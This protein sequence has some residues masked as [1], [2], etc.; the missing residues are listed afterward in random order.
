MSVKMNENKIKSLNEKTAEKRTGPFSATE[1]NKYKKVAEY[2]THNSKVLDVGCGAGNFSEFIKDKSCDYYGIEFIESLA[3]V[4]LKKG[5]KILI[6]DVNKGLPFDNET[7]DAVVLLDVLEHSISP[8]NLLNEC[9][10][11]IKRGGR[12]VISVPNPSSLANIIVAV[13]HLP[14][15][16]VVPE[17]HLQAFTLGEI[18][19]LFRIIGLKFEEIGGLALYHRLPPK[20]SITLGNKLPRIAEAVI[21]VGRKT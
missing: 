7:F 11:V 4:G 12:I 15:Y 6:H 13:F 9:Y 20:L 17:E 10:R 21:Y 2:I 3:D 18:K 16:P 14:G 5:I 8:Y 19:N 1:E